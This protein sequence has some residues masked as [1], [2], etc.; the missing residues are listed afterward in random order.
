M[1]LLNEVERLATGQSLNA[2]ILQ[3]NQSANELKNIKATIDSLVAKMQAETALYTS[4]DLAGAIAKI[5]TLEKVDI[6]K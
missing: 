2:K 6:I 4:D 1:A 3:Y 5:D